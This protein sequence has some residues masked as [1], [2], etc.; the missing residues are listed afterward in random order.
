MK[1]INK[2]GKK[3]RLRKYNCHIGVYDTY[4]DAVKAAEVEELE[5]LKFKHMQQ[6]LSSKKWLQDNWVLPNK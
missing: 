2:H 4:D 5:Q 3:W 6:Y 1:G